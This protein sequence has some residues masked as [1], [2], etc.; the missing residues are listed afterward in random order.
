MIRKQK[1]QRYYLDLNPEERDALDYWSEIVLGAGTN[2]FLKGGFIRDKMANRIRFLSLEP[3]DIDF[4]VVD[5]INKV[6][7]LALKSG[8]TIIERRSRKGTPVFRY[9]VPQYPN[10]NFEVGVAMGN[11]FTYEDK[12]LE[13]IRMDD[14]HSTDLNVNSM[15]VELSVG[16][17]EIY[18]PLNGIDAIKTGLVSLVDWHSLYRNPENVLRTF[19]VADRINCELSAQTKEALKKHAQVVERIKRPFLDLQLSPILRSPN[20]ENLWQ[21]LKELNITS[22]L[23]GGEINDLEQAKTMFVT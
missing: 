9:F 3:N 2:G 7:E 18:D 6:T 8:A 5:K 19:R 16:G 13:R 14:I 1:C 23:L 12:T 21:Q 20:S 17:K 4:L 15:S 11:V 22:Y 10:M